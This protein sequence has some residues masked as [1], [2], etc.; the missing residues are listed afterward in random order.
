MESRGQADNPPPPPP[1]DPPKQNY[2]ADPIVNEGGGAPADIV[3]RPQTEL[4]EG[5]S[6]GATLLA[7]HTDSQPVVI[8]EGGGAPSDL[9]QGQNNMADAEPVQQLNGAELT[10]PEHDTKMAAAVADSLS[11]NSGLGTGTWALADQSERRW[12]MDNANADMRDAMGL[13]PKPM[14]YPEDLRGTAVRGESST[15][16]GVL[17][18]PDLLDRSSPE[19]AVTNLAHENRHQWQD[20]VMAGNIDPPEGLSGEALQS[21]RDNYVYPT[22]AEE[23]EAYKNNLLETDARAFA[24]EV[25]AQWKARQ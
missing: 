11:A 18:N 22:N 1:P 5:Q 13:S 10:S 19:A 3:E 7:D 12:A 15:E 8:D 23:Y 24:D 2:E 17:S 21:A 14:G 16:M 20:E 4:P 9:A 25:V 6:P